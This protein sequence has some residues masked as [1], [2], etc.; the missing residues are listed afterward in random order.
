MDLDQAQHFVGP[1]LEPNCLRKELDIYL[2][3]DFV[4]RSEIMPCNKI[5]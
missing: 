1:D 4:S 5:D 3:H 2:S